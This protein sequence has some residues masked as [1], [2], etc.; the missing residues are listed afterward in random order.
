MKGKPLWTP[1]TLDVRRLPPLLTSKQVAAL[2]GNTTDRSVRMKAASGQLPARRAVREPVAVPDEGDSA[3]LSSGAGA[4]TP[5]ARAA[6]MLAGTVL[7]ALAM[8]IHTVDTGTE[9]QR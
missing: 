2:I 3:P 8:L 4:V 5:E 1:A 6:L 7:G 9:A